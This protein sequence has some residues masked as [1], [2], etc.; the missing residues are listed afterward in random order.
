MKVPEEQVEKLLD[1]TGLSGDQR[2][3]A[4]EIL[5]SGKRLQVLVGP[6]GTGKSYTVG[7]VAEEAFGTEV[8]GLA[9]S[10]NAVGVLR[11]EGIDRGANV[12]Q[13]LDWHEK[14]RSGEIPEAYAGR[15]AIRRGQLVVIDEASMIPAVELTKIVEIAK[16]A[17]AKLLVT[18]DPNQLGAVGA[19][20]R[21]GC[22]STPWAPF[23]SPRCGG[24]PRSGNGK[25]HCAS[26]TAMR[27]RCWSTTG[28]GA[29]SAGPRSG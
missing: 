19:G 11:D 10:Q 20:G 9:V 7:T 26:A 8:F 6:A 17:D 4:G 21:C 3:A 27:T 2:A 25:P 15:Y 18:G 22:S 12:T 29:C 24:S 5:G 13:F 1:T 16:D 14:L 23:A 28:A